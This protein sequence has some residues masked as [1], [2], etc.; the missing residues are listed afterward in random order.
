MYNMYRIK[1]IYLFKFI[2][3]WWIASSIISLPLVLL[4]HAQNF[5]FISLIHRNGCYASVHTRIPNLTK[6]SNG[7]RVFVCVFRHLELWEKCVMLS[8]ISFVVS[9]LVKSINHLYYNWRKITHRNTHLRT[10]VSPKL[11]PNSVRICKSSNRIAS[12]LFDNENFMK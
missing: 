12:S 3:N 8:A 9:A 7:F 4:H 5:L 2:F 10:R 11:S 6:R 1:R